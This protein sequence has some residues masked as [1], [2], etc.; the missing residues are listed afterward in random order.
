MGYYNNLCIYPPNNVYYNRDRV[1]FK[2]YCLIFNL[3]FLIS[4]GV[5]LP[6]VIVRAMQVLILID[7]LVYKKK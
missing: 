1:P 7:I 3:N 6:E 2:N 4:F 5:K